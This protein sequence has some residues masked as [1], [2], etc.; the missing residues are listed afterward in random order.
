MTSAGTRRTIAA[1]IGQSIQ[2]TSPSVTAGMSS[3]TTT[4]LR[5]RRPAVLTSQTT[6]V[7]PVTTTPGRGDCPDMGLGIDRPG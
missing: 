1:T 2:L 7:G 3:A 6:W 4:A 5:T